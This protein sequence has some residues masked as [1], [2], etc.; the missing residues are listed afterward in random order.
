[1][2]NRLP[3]DQ[4]MEATERYISQS[5][6][7]ML[8]MFRG[9]RLLAINR[10]ASHSVGPGMHLLA[11]MRAN[12]FTHNHPGG[13]S[14]DNYAWFSPPDIN[15]V[16]RGKSLR[17][18]DRRGN[19]QEMGNKTPGGLW[20]NISRGSARGDSSKRVTTDF[21]GRLTGQEKQDLA[22]A[23]LGGMAV[24]WGAGR[25]GQLAGQMVGKAIDDKVYLSG[26]GLSAR[27]RTA[28][29]LAAKA[30]P[31]VGGALARKAATRAYDRYFEG[32]RTNRIIAD[33]VKR[34]GDAGGRKV[35]K[36]Q[37][38]FAK[39]QAAERKRVAADMKRSRIVR[40]I[41]ARQAEAYGRVA[42]TV[43]SGDG[44]YDW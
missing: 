21:M 22:V 32:P 43:T 9:D 25:A 23:Q 17:V 19:W 16:G 29:E 20:N 27:K 39:K 11:N 31:W 10:G 4:R 26:A 6:R 15:S 1:M 35:G 2:I 3:A 8:G 38:S 12:R 30:A 14:K 37:R 41:A 42:G 44:R 5:N 24:G 34:T 40:A 33:V 36:M 18:V 7:E 28:G 13:S